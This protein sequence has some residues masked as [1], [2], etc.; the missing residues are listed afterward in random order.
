MPTGNQLYEY[1]SCE[2]G[3]ISV[4][5]EGT[6]TNKDL[7]MKGIFIQGDVRNQNHRVYPVKE[8][9]RAVEDISRR[10]QQNNGVFGEGEHPAELSINI[11]RISHVITEMWMDGQNGCGKLKIIQTPIGNIVK[12]LIQS[13]VKLG[14]SS[15]GSGNV[16]DNGYVS[17]FEIVTVDIVVQ[18][19]A[20]NAYPRVIYESLYNMKGGAKVIEVAQFAHSS[21]SA[22]KDVLK[23]ALKLIKE[24]K[25]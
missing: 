2:K 8:I 17:D 4:L 14:V 15:R 11:D 21:N 23:G 16:D 7:Y 19:S 10:I 18:P 24:L 6:G 25:I 13:G 22:K 5:E 20:P 3:Q 12:T 1:V 9:E